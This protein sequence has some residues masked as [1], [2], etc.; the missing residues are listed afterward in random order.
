MKF[1]AMGAIVF[2]AY[3]EQYH[4]IRQNSANIANPQLLGSNNSQLTPEAA[5]VS[6][7]K[8][9]DS[10]LR[11]GE[12]SVGVAFTKRQRLQIAWMLDYFGVDCIEISPII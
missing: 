4:Y 2:V 3:S 12:Q 5:S 11:E 10:T 8:I 1:F 7:V 9:L 6:R